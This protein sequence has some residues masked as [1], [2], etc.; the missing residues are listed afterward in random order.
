[1]PVD[2]TK[3]EQL[4]EIIKDRPIWVA[5]STHTGEEE[6]ILQT[7]QV[8]VREFTELLTVIIPRH[9]VRASE[10]VQICHNMGFDSEDICLHSQQLPTAKTTVWIIDTIG[11]LGLFFRLSNIVFMGK[12]L[13]LSGGGHNPIEPALLKCAVIYGPYMQNFREVC[14][15]LQDVTYKVNTISELL[16]VVTQLLRQPELVKNVGEKAYQTVQSQTVTL[17]GLVNTIAHE[18]AG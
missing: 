12:S 4:Q 16:D 1:L 17:E 8:L 11:E 14:H 9:P 2:D 18:V 6:L 5:A 3:L 13:L 15:V 7:H 10:I